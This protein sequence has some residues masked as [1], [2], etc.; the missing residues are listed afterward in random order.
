M[1]SCGVGWPLSKMGV[2]VGGAI[3]VSG[4]G[5]VVMEG[6]VFGNGAKATREGCLFAE[7]KR[8]SGRNACLVEE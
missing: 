8:W 2:W 7:E 3:S 5:E 4:G 1:M 6:D